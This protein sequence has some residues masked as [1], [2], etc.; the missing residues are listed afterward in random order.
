MQSYLGHP[1]PAIRRL[2][3]L[4][5]EV[6]S[7]RT[8]KESPGA[9]LEYSQ[10]DEI[11]QL[12]AG[13]ES[14]IASLPKLHK[15]PKRLKFG[16]DMWEGEGEGREEARWFRK[17]V[18]I[19][20]GDAVIREDDPDGWMLGWDKM[21]ESRPKSPIRPIERRKP[22]TP[23]RKPTATSRP[24]IVMLD[25][26]QAADPLEGYT[27]PSP[28]S[29]RSPSPTPSYLEEV[30]A[31]P[32]LALDS[33]QKKKVQRPVY[34]S[35]LIAL[36]K[37]RE[38]PDHLEM[39]LKWGEGLVRAKRSFGGELGES[40]CFECIE[41]LIMCRGKCLCGDRIGRCTQ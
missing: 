14:D 10:Q 5:A 16:K 18:G 38:K 15:V 1:D 4:I 3:M 33:T 12:K 40:W 37:E 20:D 8:I 39:A 30:A 35:Q 19:R 28:S 41:V 25:D 36:L 7:E 27:L 22:M 6:V 32:S 9:H 21:P 29:S 13:L 26:E 17:V 11:E 23:P 34:I 31:D 24:K 2:G